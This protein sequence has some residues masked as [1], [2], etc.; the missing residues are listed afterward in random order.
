MLYCP[1]NLQEERKRRNYTPRNTVIV[2][3]TKRLQKIEDSPIVE[4]KYHR[5]FG[6]SLYSGYTKEDG[7]VYR[8]M[9]AISTNRQRL[10]S[11]SST[12][13]LRIFKLLAMFVSIVVLISYVLLPSTSSS[14]T[15]GGVGNDYEQHQKHGYGEVEDNNMIVQLRKERWHKVKRPNMIQAAFTV[16]EYAGTI[17]QAS[18]HGAGGRGSIGVVSL[19]GRSTANDIVSKTNAKGEPI[20]C[21][22]TSIDNFTKDELYP[23]EGVRHMITPPN[24]GNISHVCCTTTKGPLSFAIHHKWA[25]L[26]SQRV[27]DMVTSGYFSAEGG[28]P[29]M[30]CVPNFLCQ[31]GIHSNKKINEQFKTNLQ[32]D[33]N[34]LPEGKTYRM[35][36]K[37]VKRFAKGYMAYAGAG[38]NT[39]GKQLIVALAGNGPLGGGSPWEVP[40]GEIV[41]LYSFDTLDLLHTGYGENGPKQSTLNKKGMTDSMRTKEFPLLDYI[42]SCTLVDQRNL[43]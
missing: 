1:S 19:D 29:F 31:F 38:K 33:S 35:N 26:G 12:D 27:L 25:P 2:S 11:P 18:S 34:W 4:K 20:Y 6:P 30:R 43:G 28:V 24:G 14:S 36:E 5:L 3:R 8:T 22:Y 32:D 13:V 42:T 23:N 7:T 21:P 9:V 16:D 10:L 39:R 17:R 15:G 40:W 37:G 41:G